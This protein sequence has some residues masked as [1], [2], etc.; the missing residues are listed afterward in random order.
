[1]SRRRRVAAWLVLCVLAGLAPPLAAQSISLSIANMKA[2]SMAPAPV[3]SIAATQSRPELG[4]YTVSLE[5]S[6]ESAFARPFYVN[7]AE[8]LAVTFTIDSLLTEKIAIS[9]RARLID[10]FGTVVAEAIRQHPV[11]AW[12]RLVAPL[13]VS[14]KTR[15]PTFVWTSPVLSFPP[16]PWKYEFS[17]INT[18]T[19][20]T[21]VQAVGLGDTSFTLPSPLEVNT[22]YR[23][24]VRARAQ[25][26]R[27][28]GEVVVRSPG[29]FVLAG[30]PTATIFY[31][32][33]P[34]PFGRDQSRAITCLWF[35]LARPSKVRLTV[36]DLRLRR[37]R[38]ILPR[39]G[40]DE[41][42]GVGVH[43]REDAANQTGCNATPSA[44]A[45]TWDGR[46]DAGRFVPPGVYIAEFQGDG[47]RSTIKMLY[48]GP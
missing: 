19:G 30:E 17:V 4:P 39:S 43:G 36:Y 11:Q 48:K 14:L 9:M 20:R 41:T 44:V 38:T 1:M 7:A 31:Q 46:D 45:I 33:F 24:Q 26:S 2:D 13:Q 37:V 40:S 27:G 35:D 15:Q 16:G 47:V 28:S 10:R 25:N 18:V 42:L 23:W 8:S 21:E 22:S 3:I 12:V 34:N 6:T 32:N 29:T 5:L